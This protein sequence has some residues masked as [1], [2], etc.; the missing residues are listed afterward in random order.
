MTM[1][2]P[3]ART[4]KQRATGFL[5]TQITSW[6]SHIQPST[7]QNRPLRAHG[8]TTTPPRRTPREKV[9]RRE[10]PIYSAELTSAK[11]PPCLLDF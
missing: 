1:R 10:A 5:H 11:P 8:P 2:R 9:K 3:K 7:A 6:H 4:R